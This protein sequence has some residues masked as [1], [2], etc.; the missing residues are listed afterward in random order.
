MA[1]SSSSEKGPASKFLLARSNPE[2]AVV[3]VHIARLSAEHGRLPF[4]NMD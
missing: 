1:H 4:R 3:F 2:S